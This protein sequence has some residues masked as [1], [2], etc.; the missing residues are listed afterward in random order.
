MNVASPVSISRL[1]MPQECAI[2][3]A[4]GVGIGNTKNTDTI[5][6]PPRIPE[7]KAPLDNVIVIVEGGV[8]NTEYGTGNETSLT[9]SG[10]DLASDFL[11]C[12]GERIEETNF[13]L[14]TAFSIIRL[15]NKGQVF[16]RTKNSMITSIDLFN[17][18]VTGRIKDRNELAL[19]REIKDNGNVAGG[20]EAAL[21]ALEER[22]HKLSGGHELDKK[23]L[24]RNQRNLV[25][26]IGRS[27]N[28][29]KQLQKSIAAG[30]NLVKYGNTRV[31][32]VEVG[33]TTSGNF[34]RHLA[35]RIGGDVFYLTARTGSY[36]AYDT[37]E[38]I[39]QIASEVATAETHRG[40]V[41][42]NLDS[43]FSSDLSIHNIDVGNTGKSGNHTLIFP[44][45]V[46]GSFVTC[47]NKDV[48][49]LLM[50]NEIGKK[51]TGHDVKS[52]N[53]LE[54][55]NFGEDPS[56]V[57]DLELRALRRYLIYMSI[58]HENYDIT[59]GLKSAG[60]LERFEANRFGFAHGDA[61]ET[62]GSVQGQYQGQR[63]TTS[64]YL[65]TPIDATPTE[66]IE[67]VVNPDGT[68]KNSFILPDDPEY[69]DFL[70]AL[71]QV[72]AY[73]EEPDDMGAKTQAHLNEIMINWARAEAGEED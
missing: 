6:V 3:I 4:P 61:H 27:D 73:A 39:L 66:T 18:K 55:H 59:Y 50:E 2:N 26:V 56:G 23:K 10:K 14:D 67:T 43:A 8:L 21:K 71:F 20:L 37:A 65:H 34:F 33:A 41:A 9:H 57:K 72:K 54:V 49:Y 62:T 46:G 35:G 36:E 38:S 24:L 70:R 7:N 17:E 19:S 11:K 52:A 48:R 28:K 31:S 51:F 13:P 1:V 60:L 25:L 44:R 45:Q 22:A 15:D 42:K 12:L 58:I 69:A 29:G 30:N 47:S 40:I 5:V 32:F 63:A 53:P 64:F 68:L 16:Q